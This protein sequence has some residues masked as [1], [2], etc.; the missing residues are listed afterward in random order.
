[1]SV[2]FIHYTSCDGRQG[3]APSVFQQLPFPVC[4]NIQQPD[5]AVFVQ[6]SQAGAVDV[7]TRPIETRESDV[8][9]ALRPA[10]KEP[11]DHLA[12]LS[13]GRE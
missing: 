2:P 11:P 13:T 4:E 9:H 12:A 6:H 7:V 8:Q 3:E 10:I 1:M 5:V